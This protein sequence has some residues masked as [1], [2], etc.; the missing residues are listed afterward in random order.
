MCYS[1]PNQIKQNPSNFFNRQKIIIFGH[2]NKMSSIL[3]E[4]GI[5][6]EE[7]A[8]KSIDDVLEELQE[9]KIEVKYLKGIIETNL[10][11]ILRIQ[12][13]QEQ[14]LTNVRINLGKYS[15]QVESLDH[16]YQEQGKAIVYNS[17]AIQSNSEAIQSN[18]DEIISNFDKHSDDIK[19]VTLR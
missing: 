2:L 12:E 14:D 15:D 16:L 3:W 19:N 11:E 10:T 9:L 18:S 13:E 6:A 7:F 1:D 4:F 5:S 8:F 17:K